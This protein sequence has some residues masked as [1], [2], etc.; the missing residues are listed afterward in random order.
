V[1]VAA[2]C[3]VFEEST[4]IEG[5]GVPRFEFVGPTSV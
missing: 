2:G 3:E 1:T 4:E 5:R